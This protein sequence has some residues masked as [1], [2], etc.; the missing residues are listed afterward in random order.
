VSEQNL[1]ETED[2][3]EAGVAGVILQDETLAQPDLAYSLGQVELSYQWS[4]ISFAFEGDLIHRLR[5]IESKV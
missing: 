5:H 4:C 2:L 3:K 1:E